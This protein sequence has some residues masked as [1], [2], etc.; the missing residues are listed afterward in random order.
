MKK[1]MKNV[2]HVL[3]SIW[4]F[5]TISFH[6]GLRVAMLDGIK[7]NKVLNAR[8]RSLFPILNHSKR[9]LP[10]LGLKWLFFTIP[11]FLPFFSIENVG[12]NNS[13]LKS[14]LRNGFNTS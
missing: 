10:I 1:G 3:I 9:A 12:D 5:V 13:D 14:N 7:E 2:G 4:H 6:W 8:I 11:A